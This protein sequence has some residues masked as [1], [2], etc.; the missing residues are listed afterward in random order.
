[1]YKSDYLSGIFATADSTRAAM[2]SQNMMFF[3]IRHHLLPPEISCAPEKNDINASS[4]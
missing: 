3:F 4:V 1:M 2:V